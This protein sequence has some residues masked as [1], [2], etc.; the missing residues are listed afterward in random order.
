MSVL[1][2]FD[3]FIPGGGE[4]DARLFVLLRSARCF[5]ALSRKFLDEKSDTHIDALSVLVYVTGGVAS[6][7]GH[8][9]VLEQIRRGLEDSRR[10]DSSVFSPDITVNF[11]PSGVG[12]SY[13]KSIEYR[14]VADSREHGERLLMSRKW[15]A[16]GG[17]LLVDEAGELLYHEPIEDD[18]SLPSRL[19]P[20]KP[21][22][23]LSALAEY[24]QDSPG[25][26]PLAY[27]NESAV[28]GEPGI[29]YRISAL[30]DL[31]EAD[32]ELT[33]HSGSLT[34]ASG[35]QPNP[36][37]AESPGEPSA[38]PKTASSTVSL[39]ASPGE[40]TG[41]PSPAQ[42]TAPAAS[43]GETTGRDILS[44]H[45]HR[46]RRQ[47]NKHSII[48]APGSWSSSVMYPVLFFCW[49]DGLLGPDR[50]NSREHQL[51]RFVL[52]AGAVGM[53]LG[54]GQLHSH[55]RWGCTAELGIAAAMAAAGLAAIY[56]LSDAKVLAAVRMALAPHIGLPCSSRDVINPCSDRAAQA[57]LGAIDSVS[58][59]RESDDPDLSSLEKQV[60]L[61]EY[62]LRR[63]R[64]AAEDMR[65][66][67]RG[68]GEAGDG[69]EWGVPAC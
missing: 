23:S 2:V 42:N 53:A 7:A 9:R 19:K 69:D 33:L 61:L 62:S 38:A 44:F 12:E 4:G 58:I 55:V 22:E 36:P 20:P 29:H 21:F 57:A 3:L 47:G 48:L 31:V 16:V 6:A 14:L 15:F 68:N 59:V 37:P 11:R 56:E 43:P 10:T 67:I 8:D 41:E 13:P 60:S 54:K 39:A 51:R 26:V 50:R 52:A 46:V 45:N 34:E 32:I 24:L 27:Q 66:R 30:C 64:H 18:S 65:G 1:S 25:I 63:I 5:G 40:A 49:R 35:G 28:H 17:A